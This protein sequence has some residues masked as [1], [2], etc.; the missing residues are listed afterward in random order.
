MVY[1]RVTGQA[2]PGKF[3]WLLFIFFFLLGGQYLD[4]HRNQPFLNYGIP[5]FKLG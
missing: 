2:K 1:F 3:A 4:R 5:G